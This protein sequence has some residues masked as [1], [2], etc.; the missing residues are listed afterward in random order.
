MDAAEAESAEDPAGSVASAGWAG[1]VGSLPLEVGCGVGF[2]AG[3]GAIWICCTIPEMNC[4]LS[5]SD[6]SWVDAMQNSAEVALCMQSGRFCELPVGGVGSC[7]S[8]MLACV[9]DLCESPQSL[10]HP[11]RRSRLKGIEEMCVTV[12]KLERPAGRSSRARSL[13]GIGRGRAGS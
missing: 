3:S 5:Q 13:G 10:Q 2:D 12:S 11:K 6:P 4:T 1:L 7:V 8:G 9:R